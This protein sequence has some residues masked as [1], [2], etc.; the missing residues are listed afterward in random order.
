M[1]TIVHIC[2]TSPYEDNLGYDENIMPKYHKKMGNRVYIISCFGDSDYNIKSFYNIDGMCVIRLKKKSSNYG[3]KGLE[4][5]PMLYKVLEKIHPDI[6][7]VHNAQFWG[8][9]NINRYVKRNGIKL[10]V[11]NHDDYYNSPIK[12]FKQFILHCVIFR[13]MFVMCQKNVKIFWGVT[14]WRCKYLRKVFGVSKK[15]IKL[16]PMGA[17]DDLIDYSNI[18]VI[19]ENIRKRYNIAESDFLVI[20]GGKIDKTKNI[21]LLVKAIYELREKN[22]KLFL[23]GSMD[24][25]I[26]KCIYRYIEQKN[27]IFL[28]WLNP[29]DIYNYIITSDLAVFPGTH[30][31][32]WEQ[33]CAC[34]VPIMV[35]KWDMMDHIDRGGNALF[36][37]KVSVKEIKDRI[38]L[39]LDNKEI[40]LN[41]KKIAEKRRRYFAYSRISEKAIEYKKR[42]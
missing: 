31:I 15:K 2:L 10:Y 13:F 11:D 16:L 41:I 20:S 35:K 24:D 22:V 33:T 28:G 9:W 1:K 39:L 26:S 7:Y 21:H 25:Y 14:P 8:F 3:F 29:K 40:Y 18:N 23:F 30:S 42:F 34:G 6:I 4:D 5:F 17:D 36:I 37:D 32:L 38:E 12:S 27:I 19:R